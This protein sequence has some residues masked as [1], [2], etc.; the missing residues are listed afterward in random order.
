[1]NCIQIESQATLQAA[2]DSIMTHRTAK[3]RH[4]ICSISNPPELL[5][6]LSEHKKEAVVYWTD[7]SNKEHIAGWGLAHVIQGEQS[8]ASAQQFTRENNVRLYGC[9]SFDNDQQDG[10]IFWLP[11]WVIHQREQECLLHWHQPCSNINSPNPTRPIFTLQQQP[12]KQSWINSIDALQQSFDSGLLTK[13]VFAQQNILPRPENLEPI[14]SLRQ[15]RTTE[16]KTFDFCFAPKANHAFIGRSPERLLKIN[17]GVIY[18]EALAG[19]RPRGSSETEDA[20]LAQDL[21]NSTKESMEHQIVLEAICNSLLPY[22]TQLTYPKTPSILKLSQVQHLHTPIQGSLKPNIHLSDILEALHPT[23]AVCGT[24]RS[25]AMNIIRR[26]ENFT[27]GWYAG[28][29]GWIEHNAAEFAVGIRSAL[30][31]QDHIYFWAGAGIVAQSDPISE[32]HEIQTKG[33]QYSDLVLQ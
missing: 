1:M 29:I 11:E 4:I 10:Q 19:T 33:K 30:F 17:N 31:T 27:R 8:L 25:Q 15:L 6:V 32:W 12:S 23:P 7:R 28:P 20:Y 18:T 26:T 3:N 14:S 9:L 21:L 24:P 2:V 16:D 22:V 13:V 5:E